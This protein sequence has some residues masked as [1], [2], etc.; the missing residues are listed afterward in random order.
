MPDNMESQGTLQIKVAP[1]ASDEVA[2]PAPTVETTRVELGQVGSQ[3]EDALSAASATAIEVTRDLQ[4]FGENTQI[5][6]PQAAS[7]R[8]RKW[9]QRVEDLP[10]G[11]RW[12]LRRLPEVCR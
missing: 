12:K 3:S 7:R 10:R 9:T 2:A 8:D 5:V 4:S 6:V 1:F 11:E